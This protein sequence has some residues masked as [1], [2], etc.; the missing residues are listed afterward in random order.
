MTREEYERLLKSDYWKGYSYSIIKERN[1][2]CE[3]CGRRF[4]NERNKLQV[5]H[6]VYRDV[7]PWSYRPE[8]LIVLC[9]DCHKR[10]H[11]IVSQPPPTPQE[12]SGNYTKSYSYSHEGYDKGG[13]VF[14][15]FHMPS[16][17]PVW[18]FVK[19]HKK[20]V[21][22]STAVLFV[23]L[24]GMCNGEEQT[25]TTEDAE[26]EVMDNSTTSDSR[27]SRS[28]R[29]SVT[30]G[31]ENI[32]NAAGLPAIPQGDVV[33]VQDTPDESLEEA[34]VV[35]ESEPVVQEVVT[36]VPKREETTLEILE[37]KNHEDVVRQ[38]KKA[39]VS[40]EGST[41]EIL[42]RINHAEVVK[43]AK[44]AGVSTEGS[45]IEILERISRKDLEKYGY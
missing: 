13:G 22:W 40:T 44:R 33:D 7:R 12:P 8:E 27:S 14:G 6:L 4:P 42:E 21:F 10:R 30:R 23:M 20:L 16:F 39:G 36:E 28:S 35:E 32:N 25:S 24:I 38:A 43:Q 17:Y 15:D 18:R 9:E 19:R 45:T 3:D 34:I 29:T 41:I 11:G 2:T 1:F 37:R 26:T 31:E 5:H